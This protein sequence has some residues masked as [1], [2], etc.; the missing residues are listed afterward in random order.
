[1]TNAITEVFA[2]VQE[3]AEVTGFDLNFVDDATY[4]FVGGGFIVSSL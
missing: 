1:M 2:T 4:E 3:S